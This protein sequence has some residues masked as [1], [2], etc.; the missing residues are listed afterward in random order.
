[1][2]RI[3]T[4]INAPRV[5]DL[6]LLVYDDQ[7]FETAALILPHPRMTERAFVLRPLAEIAPNWQH[8]VSS[9]HISQ[10]IENLDQQQ[11]TRPILG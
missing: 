6:D 1:M 4:G 5:I 2:K 3:R 11:I 8:P 7:I 9:T 10:L